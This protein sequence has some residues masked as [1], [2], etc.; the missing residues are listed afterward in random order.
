MAAYLKFHR[1]EAAPFEGTESARLVLATEAFR[2]AFTEVKFGLEDDCPRICLSGSGGIG[3]SSLA[4]ALPKLLGDPCLCVLIRDP[5][6]AWTRLKATLVKQLELAGGLL[7]RST[8]LQARESGRRLVLILDQAEK[9]SA[10]SLEHLDVVL[11]YRSP[12]DEQLL[13]CVLLANLE[14]A[15]KG[16]DVP[17]LWWLDRLTTRQLRFGPIP[18][19]GIRSYVDKHLKKAGWLGDG[20]LFTNSAI[21]AIHRYTGGVPGAVGAICEELLATAAD[22]ELPRVDAALVEAVCE[23]DPDPS[24]K[25]RAETAADECSDGYELASGVGSGPPKQATTR[26]PTRRPPPAPEPPDSPMEIQQ[27]FVPMDEPELARRSEISVPAALPVAPPRQRSV[28]PPAPNRS[29][30]V[31]DAALD[32]PPG[33]GRSARIRRNLIAVGLLVAALL[34]VRYWQ[35]DSDEPRTVADKAP[36]GSSFGAPPPNRVGPVT[37]FDSE[38][39]VPLPNGASTGRDSDASE[40]DIVFS[41]AELTDVPP[42]PEPEAPA[43]E[44]WSAQQP[45][46]PLAGRARARRV[47][48]KQPEVRTGQARATE[49]RR[50]PGA[51]SDSP[52]A[53]APNR[54]T[55]GPAPN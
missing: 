13:Q 37:R 14:P 55:R 18:E 42:A 17:L 23:R 54:P 16:E 2:N 19:S 11:G 50:A 53:P 46:P 15:A 12:E 34:A 28:A 20:S 27:G 24:A 33:S 25:V 49:P 45:D 26:R 40:I 5:S 44:P 48:P 52:A 3:K 30:D 41:L 47:A 38:S 21:V 36:T 35:N 9:I 10:E 39:S 1:L 22:R 8:L 6:V 4:S 31:R 29:P 7:S 51:A 43:F 32:L